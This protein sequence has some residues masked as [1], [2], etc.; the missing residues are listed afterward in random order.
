MI[1]AVKFLLTLEEFVCLVG[2]IKLAVNQKLSIESCKFREVFITE[3]IVVQC[4]LDHFSAKAI[5]QGYLALIIRIV[6]LSFGVTKTTV[7]SLARGFYELESLPR[8]G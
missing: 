4:V 5:G 1:V 6:S 8:T 7:E 3:D 2:A